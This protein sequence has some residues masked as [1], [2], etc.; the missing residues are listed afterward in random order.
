MRGL[1]QNQIKALEKAYFR[2]IDLSDASCVVD[3]EGYIG[4]SARREIEYAERNGK[5]IILNSGFLLLT[6][7][8]SSNPSAKNVNPAF[9]YRI[10]RKKHLLLQVLF[11]TGSEEIISPFGRQGRKTLVFRPHIV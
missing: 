1:T 8:V 7:S 9:P 6:R 11:S 5:E 10:A 3:L 4:P 2:R